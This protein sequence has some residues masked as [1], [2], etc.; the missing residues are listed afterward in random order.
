MCLDSV[1]T[2][3]G[4]RYVASFPAVRAIVK[5]IHAQVYLFLPFA[6]AAILFASAERFCFLALHADDRPARH[7]HPQENCT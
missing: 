3:I 5:A 7:Q 2:R 4:K 6:D 1:D